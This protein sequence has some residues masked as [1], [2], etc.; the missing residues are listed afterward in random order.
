MQGKGRSRALRVV[1]GTLFTL[2][3]GVTATFAAR[4]DGEP[5]HDVALGD[6][7]VWVTS[8]SAEGREQGMWGRVLRGAHQLDTVIPGGGETVVDPGAK[9]DVPRVDVLQDGRDVVGITATRDLVP[10]D[11]ETG[12]AGTKRG[13]APRPTYE[14]GERFF[15]SPVVDLRGGTIAMIEPQSGRIWAQ[16]VDRDG[17][18]D[19]SGL[20]PDAEPL[21]TVEQG[22]ASLVVDVEGNI[23]AV[24]AKNGKV[25]DIPV[26]GHGF[27][28]PATRTL[29]LGGRAV[30]ITALGDRWVVLDPTSGKV[31]FED[32][33]EPESVDASIS[34]GGE[35]AALL[36]ALQIPGP[37]SS[38]VA[39]ATSETVTFVG[40][41]DAPK[42]GI[43]FSPV[44]KA[45]TDKT[46][47]V[48]RPVVNGS[49]LFGV[50]S[51][52][53]TVSYQVACGDEQ[54]PATDL[55]DQAD[56]NRRN[57]AVLRINR[58]QVLVN[59]IDTGRVH[60]LSLSTQD[61][62]IDT[63]PDPDSLSSG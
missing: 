8:G 62:R 41:G 47:H 53:S 37:E 52:S 23:K 55:R 48:T 44:S 14:S 40:P 38:S 30:D 27:G 60:D 28:E 19:L 57:P 49:C 59:D 29:T 13:R 26:E 42:T 63:W 54:V 32:Q 50:R 6:G 58:G 2:A 3:V 18:T 7:G 21:A 16:R 39:V 22:P 10:I 11:P 31:W 35:S 15:R 4:S 34:T 5:V 43:V 17:V 9:E 36:A 51:Q 33:D 20:T 45:L 61:L 12:E 25:L 24:S 56:K 1:S 46:L